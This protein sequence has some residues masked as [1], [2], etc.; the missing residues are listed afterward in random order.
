M[1]KMDRIVKYEKEYM[2]DYGFESVMVWA[3]QKMVLEIMDKLRPSR[4]LEVGCG[5]DLLASKVKHAFQKWVIVEPAPKFA[6]HAAQNFSGDRRMMV[7]CE[8][9]ERTN[10]LGEF[11]FCIVSCLLHE[12][13]RPLEILA[14]L[15][16]F[17]SPHGVLHVNVPNALSMHRQLAVEMGIIGSPY[18]RSER[19]RRLMQPHVFDIRSLKSLLGNAGFSCIDEGGYFIK[20][21][22]H[23]QMKVVIDAL[24]ERLLPGLW[25]LGKKH[26]ELA[27][28]IYVNAVPQRRQ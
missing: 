3:R 28:E 5:W 2:S 23:G 12:V 18:E 4:V 19:N 8:F 22:T 10:D 16:K 17:L 9:I 14:S 26:P 27:S 15:R 13:E 25:A 24:G 7:V 6:S 1:G 11:D 21:F 20:P